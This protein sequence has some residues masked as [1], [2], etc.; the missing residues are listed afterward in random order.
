VVDVVIL[1]NG[2]VVGLR[3][4]DEPLPDTREVGQQ[5]E[6]CDPDTCFG[7][8]GNSVLRWNSGSTKSAGV[9]VLV[10]EVDVHWWTPTYGGVETDFVDIIFAPDGSVVVA[11][12]GLGTL[13]GFAP[14]EAHST[15]DLRTL[16]KGQIAPIV[17]MASLLLASAV[18]AFGPESP[19]Q[20][21]ARLGLALLLPSAALIAQTLPGGDF[22]A[23]W[24][25]TVFFTGP[26]GLIG[27]GFVL[28]ALS[29]SR[30]VAGYGRNIWPIIAAGIVAFIAGWGV[31]Y[32]SW[33]RDK[34]DWAPAAVLGVSIVAVV[35]VASCLASRHKTIDPTR[36]KQRSPARVTDRTLTQAAWTSFLFAAIYQLAVLA[37]ALA[38]PDSL[39]FVV[40]SP[41][42]IFA[43]AYG[44]NVQYRLG[45]PHTPLSERLAPAIAA[46]DSSRDPSSLIGDSEE[47]SRR[48]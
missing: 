14:G 43:W 16:R 24:T 20:E 12:E 46:T 26:F 8:E 36:S 32:V 1:P 5:L 27:T 42:V 30:Y 33:S 3:A 4:F 29:R 23:S 15:A 10:A 31:V 35:I 2:D 48:S 40:A 25:A 6:V 18:L 11:A 41:M 17:V 39:L 19:G 7:I 9:P 44:E 34:L 13:R 21:L 22:F 28:A 38:L 45:S 37:A 47:G